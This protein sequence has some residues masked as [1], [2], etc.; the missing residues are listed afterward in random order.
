MAM[1][2]S[3]PEK[4]RSASALDRLLIEDL[5][6]L[7]VTTATRII[8][9]KAS[10]ILLHDEE[11]NTLFFH[12][13]TGPAKDAVKDLR[14]KGGE[15]IAGWVFNHRKPLLVPDVSRDPRWDPTIAQKAGLST[16]SI[17]CVPLN[18]ADTMLGV[19]EVIDHVDGRP[20]SEDD[21]RTLI[22]FAELAADSIMKA[23]LYAAERRAMEA[24]L[25]GSEEKYRHII[26][27]TNEGFW[28]IDADFRVAQV[29]DSL[30]R[31][32]GYPRE[33][34][35]GRSPFD[36]VDDENLK[37]FME[38]SRRIHRLF[39]RTYD[40][41]LKS[42]DGQ[43]IHTRFNATMMKDGRDEPAGAFTFITDISDQKR[44][45]G[46][47]IRAKERAEEA[48][49]LRDKFVTLVSHDLKAPLATIITYLR[50]MRDERE[51]PLNGQQKKILDTVIDYGAKMTEFISEVLSFSRLSTGA[52]TPRFE[53]ADAHFLVLKAVAALGPAA[54]AKGVALINEVP[55]GSRIWADPTL[56]YEVLHNLISNAIKFCRAGGRVTAALAA[57]APSSV[58]VA[59]TGVG[60]DRERLSTL[61]DYETKTSTIGTSG[62]VGTG[63]GLP[64]C[65]D[66]MRAHNGN[67]RAES[68]PGEGSTFYAELPHIMPA[69]LIAGGEPELPLSLLEEAGVAC[70]AVPSVEE[71]IRQINT[72][73]HHLALLFINDRHDVELVR[74]LR[75]EPGAR[76][77][78][79]I[80]ISPDP[81]TV[82]LLRDEGIFQA[83]GP[84]DLSRLF[85]ATVKRLFP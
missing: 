70:I 9:A 2:G 15:G 43:D 81:A 61:F 13:A 49:R 5:L 60:I 79:I 16:T 20:L 19:I 56:F 85:P 84:A 10:S 24:A 37:I 53:F 40:V 64:L 71:A 63:L 25:R 38:Q 76:D 57:G 46:E 67:L 22:A 47:L 54:E 45:H 80:A 30:C 18:V 42:K 72:A 78:K 33:E 27:A 35:V 65:S 28:L 69:A 55:R 11:T 52:V 4:N 68:A 1:D 58:T 39:H 21:L 14:L 66:I 62:E 74:M 36:F 41:V 44:T 50:M 59:D 17:A 29:N 3:G 77:I 6:D 34:I 23:R 12:L 7:I 48:I 32:L 73:P 26:N 51:A 82:D 83:L 75:S 8:N 31:M